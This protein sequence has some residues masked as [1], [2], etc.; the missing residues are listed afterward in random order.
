M[1]SVYDNFIEKNLEAL[2]T[3]G[4]YNQ[5]LERYFRF[6]RERSIEPL[7]GGEATIANYLEIRTRGLQRPQ[8]T[9]KKISAALN[10]L[11]KPLS[12]F[13]VDSILIRRLIKA[14]INVRTLTPSKPK[15]PLPTDQLSGYLCN[16]GDNESLSLYDLRSKTMARARGF[17]CSPAPNRDFAP[18]QHCGNTAGERGRIVGGLI[19]F[20]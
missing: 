17:H 1:R 19:I 16:L 10:T 18:L 9:L 13:S 20:S 12:I 6:C 2:S 14:I 5:E 3:F 11:F 8:S 7:S 15:Q 4:S